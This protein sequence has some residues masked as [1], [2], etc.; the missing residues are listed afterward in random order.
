LRADRSL[1]L[2]D[3]PVVKTSEPRK[4]RPRS[5]TL[6]GKA[7]VPTIGAVEAP[8]PPAASGHTFTLPLTLSP[9]TVARRSP[10]QTNGLPSNPAVTRGATLHVPKTGLEPVKIMKGRFNLSPIDEH[11]IL[12]RTSTTRM[13]SSP[14]SIALRPRPVN[15]GHAVIDRSTSL[16]SRPPAPRKPDNLRSRALQPGSLARTQTPRI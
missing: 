3:N 11:P 5:G 10:P 7:I 14:S 9:P 15:T 2:S 13:P 12:K 6:G 8:S 1:G 4:S 16:Q